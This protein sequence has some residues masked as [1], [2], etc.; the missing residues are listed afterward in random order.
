MS[1]LDDKIL[2]HF[3]KDEC[4][5]EE[6]KKI[7]IWINESKENA[8]SLFRAEEIYNLGK[9][10]RYENTEG[11]SIAENA[12]LERIGKEKNK[13]ISRRG[14]LRWFRYAAVIIIM[15]AIGFTVTY[16]VRRHMLSVE[17]ITACTGEAGVKQIIL[18]DGTKVWLNHSS[19]L[20]YP[21]KFDG[22]KRLITLKGEAYFEVTPDKHK[23]FIVRG[24]AMSVEVLGTIF[25]FKSKQSEDISEVSLIRGTVKAYGNRHEGLIVLSPDQKVSLDKRSGRMTVHQVNASLDALW[26][27]NLIPFN[28]SNIEEIAKTLERL[29]NVRISISSKVNKKATYSGIIR[30]GS[31]IDS[32]LTQ[33]SYSIPFR[34]SRIKDTLYLSSVLR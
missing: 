29:Y 28:N 15:I 30:H 7:D 20:T 24:N 3:L 22:G 10:S 23:P 13:I 4:S 25:N 16:K 6:L 1:E 12:L 33:M 19:E 11:K 14:T 31:S 32:V 17:T 18:P 26:H 8:E 5:A 9:Y 2:E 27:D 21:L 34:I